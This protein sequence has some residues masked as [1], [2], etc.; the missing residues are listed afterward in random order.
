VT[1][2]ATE[3]IAPRSGPRL[4]VMVADDHPVVR[5]GMVALLAREPDMCVVF[6]AGN[7]DEA[8]AG[9]QTQGPDVGLIDL[10][11]PVL[12]GFDAVAAIRRASRT[13]RLVVMTTLGGDEDVYRALQAGASGYLLKDCGRA[14]LAACIRAV[15]RGQKYLQATAATRLADRITTVGLTGRE[16]NVLQGLAEGLSNKG[17]ARQ[18]GVAEGTVKTHVKAL[19]GKLD[20]A[21]RT[22]AVRLALQRGLVRLP[23]VQGSQPPGHAR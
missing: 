19:M 7:G 4:R 17:I 3:P 12:D 13:A 1:H 9:W 5:A 16:T 6:E 10:N 23:G 20:V 2:Q 8:V 14:E 22:H 11:M 15:A 18:L 21:S